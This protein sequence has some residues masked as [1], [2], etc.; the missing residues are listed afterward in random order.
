MGFQNRRKIDSKSIG[1]DNKC[2]NRRKIVPKCLSPGEMDTLA[3][4]MLLTRI[5]DE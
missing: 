5:N 2:S 4:I 1:K 3:Q